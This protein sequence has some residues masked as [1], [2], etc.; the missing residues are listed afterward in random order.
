MTLGWVKISRHDTKGMNHKRKKKKKKPDMLNVFKSKN[1]SRQ[2][3]VKISQ[4]MG[5]NTCKTY[6]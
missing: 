2:G 4:R 1:F 6:I 3:I 5:E